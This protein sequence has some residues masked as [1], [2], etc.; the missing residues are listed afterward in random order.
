[1]FFRFA[2]VVV[3]TDVILP[4]RKTSCNS[5]LGYAECLS[6]RCYLADRKCDGHFDCDDGTDEALCKI[7]LSKFLLILKI[8]IYVYSD[9]MMYI[10]FVLFYTHF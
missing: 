5:T 3:F 9:S 8:V 4:L 6:G 2:G 1:M 7:L 10:R